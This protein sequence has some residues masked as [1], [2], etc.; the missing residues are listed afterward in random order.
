MPLSSSWTVLHSYNENLQIY[1][2]SANIWLEKP[3]F[4]ATQEHEACF[5]SPLKMH[6]ATFKLCG[7]HSS[8]SCDSSVTGNK[9][10]SRRSLS[11]PLSIRRSEKLSLFEYLSERN[12]LYLSDQSSFQTL[13]CGD[14]FR[15]GWKRASAVCLQISHLMGNSKESELGR[16]RGCHLWF[17]SS[18][19][20][21]LNIRSQDLDL[22]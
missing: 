17:Y 19:P 12:G 13:K 9:N 4:P 3:T 15:H 16:C 5:T 1:S 14:S 21:A 18:V 20:C 6:N 22:R 2:K 10:N 8:E 11:S 7:H